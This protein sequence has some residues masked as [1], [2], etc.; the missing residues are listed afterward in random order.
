MGLSALSLLTIKHNKDVYATAGG[1]CLDGE[2]KGKY[3]GW[4]MIESDRWDPVLNTEPIY[5]SM[6][7]AEEAMQ[8]F[9][10]YVRDVLEIPGPGID[11]P[12]DL[13]EMINSIITATKS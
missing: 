3:T 5:E 2:G 7:K 12:K 4:I 10:D 6:E 9:I 13:C 1:P 8:K 11:M